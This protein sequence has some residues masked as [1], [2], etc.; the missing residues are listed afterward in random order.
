M[1][2]KAIKLGSWDKYL[3]ATILV[4]ILLS[5]FRSEMGLRFSRMVLSLPFF[6]IS[7]I[8]PRLWLMDIV[9]CWKA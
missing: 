2:A 6:G 4:R 5:T 1:G 9:P 8:M 7:E 3:V